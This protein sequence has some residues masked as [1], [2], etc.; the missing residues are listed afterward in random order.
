MSTDELARPVAGDPLLDAI[1][2]ARAVREGADEAIR[3]LLAYARE[4]AA[5]R[6]YRLSDLAEASG[7]S[8]SGVRTAYSAADV[9]FARTMLGTPITSTV[10]TPEV[11]V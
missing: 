8:I 1:R 4:V 11:T 3:V 5:P 2:Q 10:P 9:Q 6:P 7:L